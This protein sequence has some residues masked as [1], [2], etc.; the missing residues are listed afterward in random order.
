MP[1]QTETILPPDAAVIEDNRNPRRRGNGNA[2]PDLGVLVHR[3]RIMRSN[4]SSCMRK[5]EPTFSPVCAQSVTA[6]SWKR[7]EH[8]QLQPNADAAS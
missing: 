8:Q 3:S 7:L 6:S 1:D 2:A 5:S 4:A